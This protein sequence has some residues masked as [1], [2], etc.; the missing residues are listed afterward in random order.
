MLQQTI[1]S[2]GAVNSLVIQKGLP[3]SRDNAYATSSAGS[4]AHASNY[5]NTAKY[6][7]SCVPFRPKLIGALALYAIHRPTSKV[8]LV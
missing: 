3:K 6:V 5:F 7:E 1:P 4:L 8:T 2:S